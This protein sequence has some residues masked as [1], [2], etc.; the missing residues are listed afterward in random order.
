MADILA[1]INT[2][3]TPQGQK[4][5]EDQ[6]KN[7]AGGYVF[8]IG[9]EERLHRFLTL[10]TDGDTYY[11][12]AI[13]LTRSNAEVVFRMA[14]SKPDETIQAI[15]DVSLAGRAPKNKQA[16]FA[17]AI[18]AS[19]EEVTTRQK[20]LAIMHQ[21]CRTGT[22]V[23][24]FNKYVEQFRGRGPTLN[25]AVANWYLKKDED[26]LAYQVTKYRHREDW[27]H[28][29][30]LRLVKP[31][32]Y[33]PKSE[34]RSAIF[35][36]VTGKTPEG[37]VPVIIS[38]YLDAKGAVQYETWVEIINRGNGISWEMLPDAALSNPAVW[39]A[40]LEQGIPQTALM[41]QLPRLTNVFGGNGSWVAPVAAQLSDPERMKQGR[42]HPIN[43]L[44][45]QRT[46]QGGRSIRGRSSW[47]PIGG[48]VD[49]LDA[50]FY[51]AYGA[52]EPANKRILIGLDVSG[53]MTR[54]LMDY[55]DKGRSFMLPIT[56]RETSAALAL[57]TMATEAP[58]S[59]EVVVF[60]S[61]GT[62]RQQ[63]L[64]GYSYTRSGLAVP[65]YGYSYGGYG[66]NY[67]VKPFDITPRRRLDDVVRATNSLPHGGTDCALPFTWANENNRDFDA[68]LILTDN[69]TWAGPIHVHQAANDYRNKVG[70]DVKLIAVGMTATNYS[71]VDPKDPSGLNVSGFDSAVPALIS[72]FAAG[73][74]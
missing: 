12:R 20:A 59:S 31:G 60:T 56:A 53:S 27:T 40:M 6:V 54:P 55:D 24:E 2:R 68:V 32:K 18:C 66:G 22:H 70:H 14:A 1:S 39:E 7:N 69:E 61:G 33:G 13:D 23:F 47:T 74:I 48:L 63:S 37:D 17:L 49:A 42:V 45:A 64:M 52:V 9:D 72:D 21:V 25:R 30:L 46:Y 73:R 57:V 4:A 28:R 65:Q 16:I 41:R 51:A 62:Q 34:K 10:G 35:D 19:V 5:R 58:G 8:Q 67:A 71:V 3:K 43:V 50:G 15:L 44:V 11:Q 36:F 26:K 38:D 29:D